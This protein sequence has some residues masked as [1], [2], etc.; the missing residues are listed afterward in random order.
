MEKPDL[1]GTNGA[2]TGVVYTVVGIPR[3]ALTVKAAKPA[4]SHAT[5]AAFSS[6][7]FIRQLHTSSYTLQR[8]TPPSGLF[9]VELVGPT[10]T[11]VSLRNDSPAICDVS[12][13]YS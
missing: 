7:S 8:L 9:P 11:I 3:T 1:N 5:N 10:T 6:R 13:V 4:Q 12:V 2:A